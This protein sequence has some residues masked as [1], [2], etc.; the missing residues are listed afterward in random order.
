MNRS[1]SINRREMD[2]RRIRSSW[3]SA[4]ISLTVIVGAAFLVVFV[5][6][7]LTWLVS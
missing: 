6:A 5:L 3:K 4:A 7:F 1:A 2:S